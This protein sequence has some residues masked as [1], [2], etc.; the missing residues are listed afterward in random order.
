MTYG[1]ECMSAKV[2][3]VG[4]IGDNPHRSTHRYRKARDTTTLLYCRK[5]GDRSASQVEAN[6]LQGYP[7]PTQ[8][9]WRLVDGDTLAE[10]A[11]R[12]E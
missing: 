2:T 11:G 3:P 9:M 6:A 8:D 1:D 10:L 4:R 12:R 7:P 5:R